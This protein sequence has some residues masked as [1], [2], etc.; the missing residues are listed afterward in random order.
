MPSNLKNNDT[1]ISCIGGGTIGSG[2]AALFI[3][4]N[5]NVTVFDPQEDADQAVR[6]RVRTMLQSILPEDAVPEVM[7]RHLTV[8]RNLSTAL[9]GADFIQESVPEIEAV[10]RST[11]AAI[12]EHA[13]P[14]VII[15]SSTSGLSISALTAENAIRGRFAIGHPFAPVHILPLV[16][17][18]PT[19]YSDPDV[20]AYLMTF[21]AA[22][23]KQPVKLNREIQRFAMN[24]LQNALMT[25]ARHIVDAGICSFEDLDRAVM[26]SIGPRWAFMGLSPAVHL[27]GG[28]GGYR[29]SLKQFGWNGGEA[30]KESLAA[31]I[32]KRF[33]DHP[34][35]EIEKWRD[36]NL[37]RI[38]GM[39]EEF[40]DEGKS[41]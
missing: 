24:R 14:D 21:Y 37:L 41:S 12:A 27:A 33:G 38:L 23:G 9:R 3:S 22:L 11:F 15:S 4:K 34:I 10:K 28:L 2:W 16:E 30:S 6:A 40:G 32:E 31:A 1:R 7:A 39:R 5:L 13:R 29:H 17:V 35:E 36:R 25:E 18:C 26:D 8:T 20:V 19:E